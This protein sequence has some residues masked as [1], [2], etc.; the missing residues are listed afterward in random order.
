MVKQFNDI[1]EIIGLGGNI[2]AFLNAHKLKI[3]LM[4]FKKI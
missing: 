4:I 3:N 2:R 1:T